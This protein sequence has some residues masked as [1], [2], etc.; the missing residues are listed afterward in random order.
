MEPAV[1]VLNVPCHIRNI[2][3]GLSDEQSDTW[4]ACVPSA[5]DAM[6]RRV[7]GRWE[8]HGGRIHQRGVRSGA[9]SIAQS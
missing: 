9:V 4:C 7:Q 2:K 1:A 8:G 6:G 3:V 5:Y